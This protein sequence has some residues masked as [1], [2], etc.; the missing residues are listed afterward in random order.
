M[1][2]MTISEAW[3][4]VAVGPTE[5]A[6]PV[7]L[8]SAV[9]SRGLVN[10]ALPTS[11][12]VIDKEA[13]DVTVTVTVVSLTVLGA[14]QISPSFVPPVAVAL[15]HRF[16]PAPAESVTPDTVQVP[17][18]AR[19][20][21]VAISKSPAVV[22]WSPVAVSVVPDDVLAAPNDWTTVADALAKFS[23]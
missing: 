18:T 2:P 19:V 15:V 14:Y 5:A 9:L 10:A 3:L 22:A 8:A 20:L 6:V 17:L 1:S 12:T 23:G 16:L 21:I 11:K 13:P 7:P 4:S